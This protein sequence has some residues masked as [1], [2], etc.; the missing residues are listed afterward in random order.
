MSG[1]QVYWK[2]ESGPL[3]Y[4]DFN[5]LPSYH[6]RPFGSEADSHPVRLYRGYGGMHG[7]SQLSCETE[8]IYI[9]DWYLMLFL[10][11]QSRI[12][13]AIIIIAL[14]VVVTLEKELVFLS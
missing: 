7:H 5:I 6:I 8:N 2:A 1:M 10:L 9:S 14:L 12:P 4:C 3:K 13:H 11:A